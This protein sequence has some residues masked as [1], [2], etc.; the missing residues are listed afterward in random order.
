VQ[1]S[2]KRINTKEREKRGIAKEEQQR[3]K[4]KPEIEVTKAP[5]IAS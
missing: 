2:P 1:V 4:R 5:N 3:I